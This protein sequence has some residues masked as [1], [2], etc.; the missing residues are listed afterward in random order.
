MTGVE[1][2]WKLGA[3]SLS[4]LPTFRMPMLETL[5]RYLPS[6]TCPKTRSHG[7]QFLR[8]PATEQARPGP[9]K[10]QVSNAPKPA[11]QQS[12]KPL[13]KNPG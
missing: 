8:G 5:S 11:D 4:W 7:S 3:I 2:L 10:K 9:T 1:L 12:L 6:E 13:M